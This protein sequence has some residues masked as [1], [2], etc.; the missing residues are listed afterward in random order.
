MPRKGEAKTEGEDFGK[1]GKAKAQKAASA[2]EKRGK[3]AA[4]EE[5]EEAAAWNEGAN[6][7]GVAK[8]AEVAA[9]AAEAARRKAEKEAQLKEEE[10]GAAKIKLRGEEKVAARKAQAHNEDT[11][12]VT[13]RA[14]RPLEARGIDAALAVMTI[15]TAEEGAGGGGEGD[16]VERAQALL[17][18]ATTGVDLDDAHPER[19][20]KAAYAR[21]L[22]RELP[23]ARAEYPSL[24]R[25]QLLDIVFRKWGKSDE[26]PVY[27]A[28]K[29]KQLAGVKA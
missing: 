17:R 14:E 4:A 3:A 28:N 29:A 19:R 20:M 5:A 6:S 9:K 22:E 21:Y 18:K 26:N 12:A 7:K 25:S 24:K 10:E 8:A 2:N 27:A 23:A 13:R 1:G 16:D 15:A 11:D